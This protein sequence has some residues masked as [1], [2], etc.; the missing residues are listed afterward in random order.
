[1]HVASGGRREKSGGKS[2]ENDETGIS[3]AYTTA[4][5]GPASTRADVAGFRL[6]G[7]PFTAW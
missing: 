6:G 2:G 5:S 1:M 3:S 4:A 7:Q